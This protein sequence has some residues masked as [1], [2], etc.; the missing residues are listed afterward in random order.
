MYI[1]VFMSSRQV[2][3]HWRLEE[4]SVKFIKPTYSLSSLQTKYP[5]SVR[6]RST[7]LI[8]CMVFVTR[9]CHLKDNFYN[10]L[11]TSLVFLSNQCD[12]SLPADSIMGFKRTS[13]NKKQVIKG[14]KDFVI[15]TTCTFWQTYYKLCTLDNGIRSQFST[16]Y[17]WRWTY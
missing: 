5:I 2:S 1:P 11:L 12:I 15:G 8:C 4:M 10:W 6:R 7:L 14:Y 3:T 16:S 9:E 13:P 17:L